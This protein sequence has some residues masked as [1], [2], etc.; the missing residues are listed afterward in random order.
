MPGA[1]RRGTCSRARRG[2]RREPRARFFAALQTRGIGTQVHYIAVNDLPL[3][4]GLGYS[5]E[6]TPLAY[7]R[8]RLARQP[9]AL[10]RAT[11]G[12]VGA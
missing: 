1:G 4:R 5:P 9:A 6:Q 2:R 3:Y 7:A 11:D 8:R 10:P 12:D